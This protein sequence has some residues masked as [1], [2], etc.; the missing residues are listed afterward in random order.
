[1]FTLIALAMCMLHGRN[2][3]LTTM[4]SSD[5]FWCYYIVLEVMNTNLQVNGRWNRSHRMARENE[6]RDPRTSVHKTNTYLLLL[7]FNC[8]SIGKFSGQGM[9]PIGENKRNKRGVNGLLFGGGD[10]GRLML[11]LLI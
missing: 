1:M 4:P 8:G 7:L 5:D 9:S 6:N 11:L 3:V 2:V 10:K